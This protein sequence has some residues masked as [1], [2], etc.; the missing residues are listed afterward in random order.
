MSNWQV[1]DNNLTQPLPLSRISFTDRPKS[2]INPDNDDTPPI[3]LR[4]H[5]ANNDIAYPLEIDEDLPLAS[6]LTN[7]RLPRLAEQVKQSQQQKEN[8]VKETLPS[9]VRIQLDQ[10]F[11]KDNKNQSFMGAVSFRHVYIHLYASKFLSSEDVR[12]LCSACAQ[13][14]QLYKLIKRHEDIDFR[15]LQGFNPNW[16]TDDSLSEE[17]RTMMTACFLHFKLETPTVIRWLGGPHVA[18]HRDVNEIIKTLQGSVDPTTLGHLERLFR[19]GSPELCNGSSSET[20]FQK[21]LAYGNHKTI[22]QDW[23]RTEKTM[24]KDA[25]RGYNIHMDAKLVQFIPHLHLTP[26]GIANLE[27]PFKKDRPFFDSSFRPDFESFAINDWTSKDNEPPITFPTALEVF[28]DYLWNLRIS[29][30]N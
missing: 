9:N 30:P 7:R 17:R 18:A 27:D 22:E 15:P 10:P 5:S 2:V 12:L 19:V 24:R 8:F 28:A 4:K 20:N 16:E 21:F 29:Y 11:G 13:A 26:Q 23:E 25:Q 14:K 1:S 6:E 3:Q